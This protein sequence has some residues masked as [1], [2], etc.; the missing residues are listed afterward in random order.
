MSESTREWLSPAE[1][2]K[3]LAVSPHTVKKWRQRG[4][5]P[6]FHRYSRGLRLYVRYDKGEL[7]A[8]QSRND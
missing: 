2:A 8:W 6:P 3:H 7:D 5:G 1:A 4:V